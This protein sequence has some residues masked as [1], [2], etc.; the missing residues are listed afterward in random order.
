[1][2]SGGVTRTAQHRGPALLGHRDGGGVAGHRR[3]HRPRW[4]CIGVL[5]RH[6]PGCVV[7]PECYESL[8]EL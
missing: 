1:M 4:L 3:L 5:G 2:G 7:G 6:R 8:T